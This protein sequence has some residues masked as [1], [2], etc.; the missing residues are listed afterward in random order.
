MQTEGKTTRTFRRPGKVVTGKIKIT[1]SQIKKARR[2]QLR[3]T[4]THNKITAFGHFQSTHRACDQAAT[5]DLKM[6]TQKSARPTRT[7][8]PPGEDLDN[9]PQRDGARSSRATHDEIRN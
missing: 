2:K 4:K 5:D 7:S 1:P 6:S 3:L 9:G 8:I